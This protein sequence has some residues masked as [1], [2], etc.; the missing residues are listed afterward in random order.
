MVNKLFL[1]LPRNFGIAYL[2]TFN[3]QTRLMILNANFKHFFLCKLINH[4]VF[5]C[6]L[7]FVIVCIYLSC[8]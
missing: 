4:D 1:L 2:R 3:L 5:I 7:I 8:S 6:Y